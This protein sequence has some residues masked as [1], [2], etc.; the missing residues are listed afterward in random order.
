MNK[1]ILKSKRRYKRKASI[2]KKLFGTAQ[3]PR[4]SVFKSNKHIYAQI[5]NDEQM[6]TIVGAS[7]LSLSGKKS[8]PV[9][10][11]KQVGTK[12]G[13]LAKKA[14]IETVVFDRSGY[15]YHGRVKAL[16]D[17]LRESGLKF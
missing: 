6:K 7:D 5:I 12:L 9:D 15:K 13:E 2:R 14:K 3:K 1:Q 10:K 11:A 4:V 8:T 17:G 16:A